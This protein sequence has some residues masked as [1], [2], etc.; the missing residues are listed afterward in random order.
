[1]PGNKLNTKF[2]DCYTYVTVIYIQS[3]CPSHVFSGVSVPILTRFGEKVGLWTNSGFFGRVPN[4]LSKGTSVTAFR[5]HRQT[6]G[7]GQQT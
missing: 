3:E 7:E 6:L 2:I 5:P 4:P 1:M